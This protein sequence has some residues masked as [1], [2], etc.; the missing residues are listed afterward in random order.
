MQKITSYRIVL[1]L[2]FAVSC[3]SKKDANAILTDKKVELQK[4]QTKRT[5]LDIKIKALEN[6]IALLDTS[7]DAQKKTRLVAVMP[8]VTENFV[9]YLDLQGKI[10][11][12][13]ISYITPRGMGGQV[14]GLFVKKGDNVRKG[15]LLVKLDDAIARQNVVTVRQ[16]LGAVQTQ[17]ALAKS[18][19]QRQK[20]L[21]EQNI[22]TEVQVLQAKTN[23]ETLQAQLNTMYENVRLAQEQ[24]AMTN[25]YSNVS[26]VADEVNIHVGETFTGNPMAGI[27]IVNTNNLKVTTDISETYVGRVKKGTPVQIVITDLNKTLQSS[28]SV[29]SPSISATSRGFYAEAKIPYDPAL[30]PNQSVMMRI[31]DYAANN[32]MVIPVNVIQTDEK[33][34]YVY[35]T[36]KLSNGKLVAKKKQVMIGEINGEKVEIKGGLNTGDEIITEGYQS[37]YDGQTITIKS[38]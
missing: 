1:L 6:V 34:K 32:V 31:Q 25:V 24:L 22:G 8:V 28:I 7:A 35:V 3:S 37:L 26:G 18:V 15:Q 17:L 38:A 30:K 9:H 13:N 12:E 36:Q 14:K 23:M 20:N 27:K 19:Y 10:D 33:G 2:F 29:V 21:W 11:A 5:D 16:S 4:L